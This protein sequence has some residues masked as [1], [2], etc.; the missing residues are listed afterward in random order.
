H[1][2]VTRTAKRAGVEVECVFSSD[3]DEDC[4]RAYEGNFGRLPIGDIKQVDEKSVRAHDLLLA[5]FPCQPFSSIGH[6]RGVEDTRG[7]LFFDIARILKEKK[8]SAFILENVKL[9]VGHD[10]GRTLQRIM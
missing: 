2:G 4:Q 9:L 1:L 10:S 8:P 3:I 5:G 6:I 7:T